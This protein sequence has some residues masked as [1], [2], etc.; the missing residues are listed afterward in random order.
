MTISP[1]SADFY[2]FQCNFQEATKVVDLALLIGQK[3]DNTRLKFEA[4]YVKCN[5]ACSLGDAPQ[6]L[7]YVYEARSSSGLELKGLEH[8][9]LRFEA[10]A[11]VILGNFPRGL[12]LCK[13]LNELVV[14]SG[15]EGTHYLGMLDLQ[16][17]IHWGKSEYSQAREIQALISSKTSANCSP[18]Y[19]ANA[20][21][22]LASLDI[23]MSSSDEDA[24]LRH[25]DGAKAVY[26]ALGGQRSLICSGVEAEW[27]L[28]RKDLQNARVA[29]E[30]CLSKSRGIYSD[31]VSSCLA[32][33]GDPR[34]KMPSTSDWT[35]VYFSLVRKL[36]DRVATFHALRCLADIF[37][38]SDDEE[39]AL[40][41][42][43]TVLEGAT[44]IDI[45]RLRA[46]SMTGIGDIMM[47]RGDSVLAKEMWD[48][49]RPLFVRS[50]QMKDAA[51]I[52]ERLVQLSQGIPEYPA[53]HGEAGK[54]GT[55]SETSA[56]DHTSKQ[57]PDTAETMGQIEKLGL[58][59]APKTSPLMDA[60]NSGGTY[61]RNSQTV[62]IGAR[63]ELI[64]FNAYS[65]VRTR[66]AAASS[67]VARL[68][69]K[70]KNITQAYSRSSTR[71]TRVT[72]QGNP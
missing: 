43:H 51:A 30:E 13:K 19:H 40:N 23:V 2:N 31:V 60:A 48:A 29:F 66:K 3:T 17:V 20:L 71:N 53:H 52:D 69:T 65:E 26:R 55:V 68:L 27:C 64:Y 33:L 32:A 28:Y 6:I 22:S 12:A 50:S 45:H 47:Q 34:H 46:E 59:A 10:E 25:L 58:L 72:I 1:S 44:E 54:G 8:Y 24:I 37:A 36:K 18:R 11:H 16:A 70:K 38:A 42:Y 49:A 61:N 41:L 4:F 57:D 35:F 15:L 39:T 5:I 7:K 63:I 14:A 62:G 67:Q 56:P 9:W 21:A